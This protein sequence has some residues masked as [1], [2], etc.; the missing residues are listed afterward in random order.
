[1]AARIAASG[2]ETW[3]P[4][5]TE[6]HRWSDRWR[7]VVTPLFP[8][9]LFARGTFDLWH[10]LLRTPGVLTVVKNGAT[11]ALLDDSFVEYLRQAVARPE[12]LPER[13]QA[14]SYNPGDEVVVLD[15]VLSGLHGVVREQRSRRQLIVWVSEIGKG[16]A[17]SI[18]SALVKR[19]DSAP[20]LPDR[21][22][23]S[24]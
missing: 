23:A 5:I 15:G 17:L 24:K 21:P 14:E 12:L 2:V 19:L 10:P 7:S 11:P 22:F 13:V 8:G 20:L 18:G 3:L 9:Y 1:M 16:V 6:T 4:T